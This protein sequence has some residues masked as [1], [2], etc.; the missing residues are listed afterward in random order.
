MFQPER[1]TLA[2]QRRG[3]NKTKMAK[4]LN[5]TPQTVSAYERGEREPSPAIVE[6]AAK[7]LN[8]PVSFFYEEMV[9][10]VPVDAASFR[11][12]TRTTASQRD[13]ALAAGAL[14]VALNEWIEE[15]FD[16][17]ETDIPDLQPGLIDPDGAAALV[18][19]RWSLG[20]A[21]IANVLHLLEAHGVRVFSLAPE[22]REV[23]AFSFWRDK[24]PYICLGT[25]K[26]P[27]R[28][29]FDLGHELGH[30]VLHRDHA[31]PR[32]RAEER[33]ADAFASNFLMPKADIEAVAP[34]FP[35]FNDLLRAK[36]RWRV[37][38]AALNYRLHNLGM[39]SDWHYRELCIEISRL[40]R[41]RELNSVAREHSQI[42]VKVFGILR[43]EGLSR[44]D[45][46]AALHLYQPDLE[47]LIFGLT[48]SSTD[49]GVEAGAK[50]ERPHLRV[51]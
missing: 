27:E 17:P 22:A 15:R 30:L 11:K 21:P 36:T 46:A 43:A 35:S 12:L 41:D 37:S 29:V 51:V 23:D 5:V 2:R 8:F 13:A 19:A 18:R 1:L 14:C 33:Q 10:P 45:I 44:A 47:M 3:K 7:E 24:T 6:R 49:G 31:A 48:V 40:G 50:G 32:G 26:T 38:A 9:D 20:D 39:T 16:L 4:A 42:L 25:H 28:A 34:R